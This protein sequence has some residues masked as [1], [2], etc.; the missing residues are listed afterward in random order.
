MTQK[1]RKPSSGIIS[2]LII[3]LAIITT[4]CSN[5]EIQY[6]A[7]LLSGGNTHVDTSLIVENSPLVDIPIPKT[8]ANQIRLK[9]NSGDTVHFITFTDPNRYFI[10][11][12]PVNWSTSLEPGIV[13]A[14]SPDEAAT[15]MFV[16]ATNDYYGIQNAT[17]TDQ[18]IDLLV[19][20][21]DAMGVQGTI[22]EIHELDGYAM[23][24]FSATYDSQTIAGAF[25]V[26]L[27]NNVLHQS[28]YLV[29]EPQF[30]QYN[31]TFNRMDQ[32]FTITHGPNASTTSATS[33]A[34]QSQPVQQS[35]PPFV[36]T[37]GSR[38]YES[39]GR[40]TDGC[41]GPYNDRSPVKRFTFEVLFTNQSNQTLYKNWFPEIIT[42][43]RGSVR[44]CFW[45]Y[46]T[47]K[48]APGQTINVTFVGHVEGDDWVA[49]LAFRD[50]NYQQFACLSASGADVA[51]P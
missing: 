16:A 19:E 8:E 25:I 50:L 38:S 48:V 34:T 27:Y 1:K 47:I 40:P 21:F 32:S 17:L 5:A 30:A 15:V 36:A 23:Y 37:L 28:M 31:P 11:D 49:G 33:Q 9:G 7:Q 39:W 13:T 29:N 41:A 20:Y 26:L 46:D 45:N 2:V 14:S 3:L 51:C 35:A 24:T 42:A 10:V 4:G 6:A 18:G 22:L 44:T 43:K 12:L